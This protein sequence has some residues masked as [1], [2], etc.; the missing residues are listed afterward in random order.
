[1]IPLFPIQKIHVKNL[2]AVLE[3]YPAVLDSSDC[4]T[5][6]TYCGS[7]L[8]R[9]HKGPILV[10]APLATLP[11]WRTIMKD[12]GVAADFINYEKLRTGRTQFVKKGKM[13]WEW[14]LPKS[15]M[16]LWDEAH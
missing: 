15:A 11:F 12:R 4:G 10:V 5:G 6:K 1:M 14:L 2:Q 9:L 13:L 7:E 3:K 16:I 8:A